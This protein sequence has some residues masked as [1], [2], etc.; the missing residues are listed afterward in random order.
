[1]P[2]WFADPS[3]A[4]RA[5]GLAS[6]GPRS[7]DGLARTVDWYETL[8]DK[9]RYQPIVEEVRP[10]HRTYSVSA[11][12]RLLQG[13]PGDPDHVRA[14]H[15]TT[16]HASSNIDYE[17][18]FVNDCSPDDSEEVIRAI[19]RDDRR[20]IGITHSRNFGSQAAFRSGMEIASQEACVLLDGDLQDPPELIEQFV[21][22]GARATTSSTAGA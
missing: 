16:L 21:A 14:A 20:V 4:E 3:K 12:R 5:A 19:S 1:M 7:D 15:A 17:I 22:S 9:P 13:R 18:I 2:D 8:P 10:R 11:D 6:R